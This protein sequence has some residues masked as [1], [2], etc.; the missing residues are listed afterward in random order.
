MPRD[1]NYEPLSAIITTARDLRSIN[2]FY[3]VEY[4]VGNIKASK[5]IKLLFQT[6][7]A[8]TV[9]HFFHQRCL[10]P[11]LAFYIIILKTIKT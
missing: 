4:A 11:L 8:M 1:L 6:A 9:P 2:K 7:A 10:G 5:D 3:A